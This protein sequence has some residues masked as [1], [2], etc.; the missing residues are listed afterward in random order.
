ML[1]ISQPVRVNREDFRA[2]WHELY[3]KDIRQLTAEYGLAYEDLTQVL[4][5]GDFITSSHLNAD[6]H[7]RFAERLA[8]LIAQ[9]VGGGS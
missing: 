5:A 6:N 9:R 3:Q 1:V 4:P 7:L 2:Q 8:D